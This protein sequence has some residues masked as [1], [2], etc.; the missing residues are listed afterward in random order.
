MRWWLAYVLL[1][2]TWLTTAVPAGAEAPDEERAQAQ[3][4]AGASAFAAGDYATA[5]DAF[6]AARDAGMPGPAVHYN[7]GVCAWRLALLD[8]AESAFL[9]VAESPEMAALAH[10][11]LGLISLRRGDEDA[12][13]EWF[14]LARDGSREESLRRLATARLGPEDAVPPPPPAASWQQV[15]LF[16]AQAGYDDNVT[17]IQDGELLG[18]PGDESAFSEFQLAMLGSFGEQLRIEA[19]G[20]VL[21][22]ATLDEFDQAGAQLGA[23]LGRRFGEWVGDAGIHLGHS[24]LD[25]Q[26]LEDRYGLTFTAARPLPQEWSLRLRYRYEEIDGKAPF[27]ALT[28]SRHLAGVRAVR[29]VAAHSVQLELQIETNDRRADSVSPTRSQLETEWTTE[30]RRNLQSQLGATWRHSR[31]DRTGDGG[32]SERWSM[33]FAGLAGDLPR[34][35]EWM[36]RYDWTHNSSAIEEFRYTRNRLF[37]GVQWVF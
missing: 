33:L 2:L 15:T 14:I 23:R 35:W 4:S 16:G 8:E 31:F 28:G 11:N 19:S 37:A 6:V 13:R 17:L 22:Y 10:Y 27:Q 21:Q 24:R 26:G 32:Y 12:A 25:H 3:F 20:Y 9:I 30:L 7:I 1:A 5:L 18:I 29:K 36:I 34:N